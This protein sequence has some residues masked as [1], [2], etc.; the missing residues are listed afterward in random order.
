MMISL[1]QHIEYLMMYHDCVVV[2]GWGALIAN[3]RSSEVNGNTI[4]HPKRIISFNS[5]ITHNDGMIA[6]SLSRRHA[7]T[8]D[9]ACELISNNV[10]AFRQQL[11]SGTEVAFGHVGYFKL[12]A[13]NKLDFMPMNAGIA[14]NEFFGLSP[15]NINPQEQRDDAAAIITPQLITWRDRIKVAA[16]AAAILALGFLF[17]T[18][19]I[20]NASTQT[21]S[22]NV[23]ELRTQPSHNI[24][25]KPVSK[26]TSNDMKFAVVDEN[27]AQ[28][29]KAAFESPCNDGMPC[30]GKYSL[31]INTCHNSQ[32]AEQMIDYYA[33]HGIKAIVVTRG[34][35]H[36]I[37]VAQSDSKQELKEV[38]QL[39]PKRYRKAWVS[40]QKS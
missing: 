38:K 1:I 27:K 18:P 3:Y 12:T 34:E 39:L 23:M 7:M 26:A 9:Q 22:L 40:K 14:L 35:Y 11:A 25:V 33:K 36:D 19:A 24:D 5:S 16:S 17:S 31:V 6:N 37:V 13:D 32:R 30:N 15:I 2:P 8:Y 10:R 4:E 21:A 29:E 28:E 20:F